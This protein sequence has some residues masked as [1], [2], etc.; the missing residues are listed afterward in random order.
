MDQLKKRKKEVESK[1]SK[2]LWAIHNLNKKKS[3][4]NVDSDVSHDDVINYLEERSWKWWT[5]LYKALVDKFESNDESFNLM[6][7]STLSLRDV[8]ETVWYIWLENNEK[9]NAILALD[10]TIAYF[11]K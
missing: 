4:H 6:E 1:P 8:C 11:S 7:Y 3:I 10:S 9:D 2:V 5:V